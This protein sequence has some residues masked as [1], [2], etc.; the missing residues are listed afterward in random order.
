MAAM[1]AIRNAI[2]V[3]FRATVRTLIFTDMAPIWAKAASRAVAARKGMNMG[4]L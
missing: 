1:A 3:T 4:F 2:T